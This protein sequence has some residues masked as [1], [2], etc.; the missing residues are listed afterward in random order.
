M[1][2][3]FIYNRLPHKIIIF[4][5]EKQTIFYNGT[6]RKLRINHKNNNKYYAFKVIN[7]E[8]KTGFKCIHI[9]LSK[10]L[11][12]VEYNIKVLDD[13][14]N[15]QGVFEDEKYDEYYIIDDMSSYQSFMACKCKDKIEPIEGEVWKQFNDLQFVSDLGRIKNVF[16]RE[17]KPKINQNGYCEIMTPNRKSKRVHQIVLETFNPLPKDNKLILEPNHKNFKRH[18][19]RLTNLEWVTKSENIRH[20]FTNP[21]RKKRK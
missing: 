1:E 13:I 16:D 12:A 8:Y 7:K 10:I 14:K 3:E 2:Y 6:E 21:N 5:D 19:N 4:D 20:S 9:A 15:Y 11:Y 17:I 18:D